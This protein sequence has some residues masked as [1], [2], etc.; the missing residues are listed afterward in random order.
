MIDIALVGG[1]FGGI[2]AAIKLL[3][4]GRDDFVIFEKA[5]SLGGTWRD[6]TYPGCGC[7]IPS[8][9]YSYSFAQHANWSRTYA[10]QSEILAYIK[11]VADRYGIERKVL[12][13]TEIVAATWDETAKLWR[14]AARDGREFTA[15]VM[16]AATGA[17]HLPKVPHFVG[18]ESFAG[19]TFHS[20]RWRHDVDLT[21]KRV[22]VIGTGA[23][24][25]QF[26]PQIAPQVAKLHLFQRS[27]PWVLPRHNRTTSR[28]AKWAFSRIPPLQRA[29][30]SLQ[31]WDCEAIAI[32]FT[33]RPKMMGTW[34]KKSDAFMRSI[35]KDKTLAD[36]LMPMY[37]MG[38]KRVLISDDFYPTMTRENVELVTEPIKEVRPTGIVTADGVEH[39]VDAIIYATGF[40]PFDVAANVRIQGRGG[41]N[42]AD[43]WR[44]GPEAFHGVAVAGYPNFFLLM[45]P[46]SALGHN[47]IIFM[48]ETQ[49]RYILQCLK[50]LDEGQQ[51]KRLQTIEVREEVQRAFNTA[52]QKRF[53][54]SV[55]KSDGSVWQL[56]CTSWY[57]HASGKNHVL[58]P[59]FS[60]S[61]WWAM[62]KPD[63][64]HFLPHTAT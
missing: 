7:D 26:V 25:I 40:K 59:G 61:Y 38:C 50:W 2:C 22:A 17:L 48:I 39:P 58:W 46:N 14:L 19:P 54:R 63:R 41:R 45:G 64:R 43:D 51:G 21:G 27:P 37:T 31:Y 8:Q 15:R 13:N 52:L 33:V 57:V 20:A 16:I 62:R 49:V 60:V 24:A 36:K 4:A 32:G 53:D 12:F 6:N 9:L 44:D 47:S 3:A 42:L 35:I 1:G 55:W 56:P 10:S 34:Q 18:G 11:G 30:R 5:G 28:I 23:S 29:W